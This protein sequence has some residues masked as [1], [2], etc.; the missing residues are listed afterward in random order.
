MTVYFLIEVIGFS[1]VK[2]KMVSKRE[3]FEVGIKKVESLLIGNSVE[4]PVGVLEDKKLRLG[5]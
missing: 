2:I 5:T 1:A 4:S 3:A